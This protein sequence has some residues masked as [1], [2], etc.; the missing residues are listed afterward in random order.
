MCLLLEAGPYYRLLPRTFPRFLCN[1]TC[2]LFAAALPCLSSGFERAAAELT[3]LRTVSSWFVLG[4]LAK[5]ETISLDASSRAAQCKQPLK[6]Q[7]V[8]PVHVPA[9]I[10]DYEEPKCKLD[11]AYN[12]NVTSSIPSD[13]TTLYYDERWR[14]PFRTGDVEQFRRA[15]GT[16]TG[17]GHSCR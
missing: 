11:P 1:R 12:V 7:A 10:V 4:N 5:Y 3:C 16:G 8:V 17:D 9:A 15:G 6:Q 2:C 13:T 14:D